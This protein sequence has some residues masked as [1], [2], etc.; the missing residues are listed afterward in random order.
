MAGAGYH[1]AR[2]RGEKREAWDF[3]ATVCNLSA[4]GAKPPLRCDDAVRT[5]GPIEMVEQSAL[6]GQGRRFAPSVGAALRARAPWGRQ[7]RPL[8]TGRFLWL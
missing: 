5:A 1:T 7:C 6:S 4:V 2:I 8:I 3:T